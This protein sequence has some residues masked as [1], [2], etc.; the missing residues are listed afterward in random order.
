MAAALMQVLDVTLPPDR[1]AWGETERTQIAERISEWSSRALLAEL[2]AAGI[3]AE[4]C[5]RDAWE[6][7]LE[8]EI[9]STMT[10]ECYGE[11]VHCIGPLIQFS[12]S[13]AAPVARLS[14]EPGEDTRQILAELGVSTDQVV[15]WLESGVVA[16]NKSRRSAERRP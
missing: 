8:N 16:E 4:E 12:R 10:D 11:V 13:K 5:M 6:R 14:P 1:T 2:D 3:W 15:A 7:G 9:V